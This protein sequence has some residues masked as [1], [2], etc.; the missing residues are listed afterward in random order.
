MQNFPAAT[1][2]NSD[3]L[4]ASGAKAGVYASSA[5]APGG[6]VTR[7][8]DAH[9]MAMAAA[10]SA[11]Q[12]KHAICNVNLQLPSTLCPHLRKPHELHA[13]HLATM[14]AAA[15]LGNSSAA[16]AAAAAAAVAATVNNGP[17]NAAAAAS[18]LQ[19]RDPSTAP[20]RKLSVDLIKTYKHINEVYYAKKKRRA[21]QTQLDQPGDGGGGTQPAGTG[22]SHPGGTGAGVPGVGVHPHGRSKKERKVYNDGFDDENHDY[23]VKPGERFLDRYEIDSLIGKNV[24]IWSPIC[25]Y[26]IIAFVAGECCKHTLKLTL[27]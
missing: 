10:I 7:P 9:L 20:L 15:T 6:V 14:A 16:A 2:Y 21:Q 11:P 23:L 22:A 24:A 27:Q 19:F 3:M 26:R 5:A 8:A 1:W 12:P 4:D 17:L 25:V 13:N 18:K